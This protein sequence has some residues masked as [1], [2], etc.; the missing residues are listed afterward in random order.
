MAEDLQIS[1]DLKE[2]AEQLGKKLALL[3]AS[4]DVEAKYKE[5]LVSILPDLDFDQLKQLAETLENL[6]AQNASSKID[7]DF[8]R[9]IK[10]A[11]SDYEKTIRQTNSTALDALK[12]LE[13]SLPK[14]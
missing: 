13:Q 10:G 12:N 3:I 2:Q 4:L 5:S 8:I 14:E 1:D 11:Q 6:Y 9:K 7:D